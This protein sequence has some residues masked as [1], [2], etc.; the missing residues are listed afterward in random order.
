VQPTQLMLQACVIM[1][2]K[3]GKTGL[4][5]MSHCLVISLRH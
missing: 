2:S 3:K 4:D 1:V 5:N